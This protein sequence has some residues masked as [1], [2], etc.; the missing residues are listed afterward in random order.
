ML[1]R[2]LP[3]VLPG[4]NLAF[5]THPACRSIAGAVARAGVLAMDDAASGFVREETQRERVCTSNLGICINASV[6]HCIVLG[7]SGVRHTFMYQHRSTTIDTAGCLGAHWAKNFSRT[8]AERG[9]ER[10]CS[11][12]RVLIRI[13]MKRVWG[14]A[15]GGGTTDDGYSDWRDNTQLDCS[16][17]YSAVGRRRRASLKMRVLSHPGEGCR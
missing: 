12:R 13:S 11:S 5:D 14:E 2:W 4:P 8:C 7:A 16:H 1:I 15:S 10:P 17:S 6:S 9:L 3:G